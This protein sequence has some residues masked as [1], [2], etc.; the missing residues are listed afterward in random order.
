MSDDMGYTKNGLQMSKD[1][2]AHFAKKYPIEPERSIAIS[3]FI[4]CLVMEI[5]VNCPPPIRKELTEKLI[6]HLTNLT[7]K[8]LKAE[9]DSSDWE[10]AKKSRYPENS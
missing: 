6:E 10:K 8:M 2:Y 5:M 3:V 7:T 4:T 1:C 9:F